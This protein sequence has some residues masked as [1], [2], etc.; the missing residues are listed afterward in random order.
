MNHLTHCRQVAAAHNTVLGKHGNGMNTSVTCHFSCC[1]PHFQH[2][3][4]E[5]THHIYIAEYYIADS[6]CKDGAEKM[7]AMRKL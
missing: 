7:A 1:Q 2:T 4:V 5:H 3:N 6:T